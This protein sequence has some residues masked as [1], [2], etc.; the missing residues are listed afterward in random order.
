MFGV[1]TVLIYP[2]KPTTFIDSIQDEQAQCIG[3][4]QTK[5]AANM[6]HKTAKHSKF[7]QP[8]KQF[9]ETGT[10]KAFCRPKA[11]F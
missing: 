7:R 4:W 6:G 11:N 1:C 2:T 9:Y 8:F 10:P 5:T 3:Y